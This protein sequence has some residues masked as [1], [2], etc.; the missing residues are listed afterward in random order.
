[1]RLLDTPPD[2]HIDALLRT[3]QRLFGVSST[4]VTLVDT[5]R[6]WFKGRIG[7]NN[8]EGPRNVSF[9]GHTILSE[10]ILHVP[11][12]FDD[13]RF[14]DNPRYSGTPLCVFTPVLPC[15]LLMVTASGPFACMTRRRAN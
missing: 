11:D 13:E 5:D 1:M 10:D 2:P 15:M 6:Q 7:A 9:C 12:A 3:A 14:V 4:L 8:L